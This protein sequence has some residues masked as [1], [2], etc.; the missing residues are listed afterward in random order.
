MAAGPPGSRRKVNGDVMIGQGF[1]YT[2]RNGTLVATV[3]EVEVNRKSGRVWPRHVVVAHDC[4]LIINPQGLTLCIE[5]NVVQ[6][7]SQVF[8]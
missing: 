8:V 6:A 3:V 5:G 7:A 1:A 4:G 2:E